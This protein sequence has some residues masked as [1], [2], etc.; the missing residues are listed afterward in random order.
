M[1]NGQKVYYYRT[2]DEDGN[3]TSGI[4][5]GQTTLSAARSYCDK[6]W[7]KDELV[8]KKSTTF[9]E[10]AE[11]CWVWG[12]CKYI[13][14]ANTYGKKSISP[15][16]AYTER[17]YL[18]NRILPYFRNYKLTSIK[19]KVIEN[20]IISL[21][22]QG[23]L[24]EGSINHIIK[25]LKIMFAEAKRR[26]LI[27]KDPCENIPYIRS[28]GK[29][30]GILSLEETR[31]LFTGNALDRVWDNDIVTYT[32][33]LF[34]ASTGCR[35][36]EIL[37]LKNANV[38]KNYV[39]ITKSFGQISGVKEITKTK[40]SRLVPIPTITSEWINRI[41]GDDPEYFLF[42]K[43]GGITPYPPH[44]VLTLFYKALEKIGITSDIRKARNITF[45]NDVEEISI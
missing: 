5:T 19:T 26:D 8:P 30:R 10:L 42:S 1:K 20:Y 21:K 33:H 9:V 41:K 6:L 45:H 44:L 7:K 28:K 15:D 16:H 36:G 18:V 35:R 13:A 43:T 24:A 39:E 17:G 34:S 4:S 27:Y 31:L 25:I 14:R 40:E 23:E 32:F 2:Y 37:S 3:R 22:A 12:K 11:D 29:E 38:H